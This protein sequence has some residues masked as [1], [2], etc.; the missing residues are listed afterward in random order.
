MCTVFEH[1]SEEARRVVVQAQEEARELG[2]GFI[3]TEHLLLGML[4]QEGVALDALTAVG[5]SWDA[6]RE[7]IVH[8]VRNGP[9]MPSGQIPFT[10][11]AESAFDR[12]RGV[13][14]EGGHANS[15]TGDLLFG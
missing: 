13:V 8:I 7:Q 6:A 2:H 10:S 11:R 14:L 4:R 1:F 5:V 9:G 12:A 3:G 15:G